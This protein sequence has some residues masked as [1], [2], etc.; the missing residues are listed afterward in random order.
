MLEAIYDTIRAI[1]W[2]E[3]PSDIS[4]API[5]WDQPIKKWLYGDRTLIE[6]TPSVL[7][8]GRTIDHK[9][10][11]N[12]INELTYQIS[13]SGWDRGSRIEVS[14]R[15]SLELTRL[16]YE[17]ILPHSIIWV[18]TPCPICLKKVL[19][20]SHFYY[21]HGPGAIGSSNVMSEEFNQAKEHFDSLWSESH[22]S[23]APN[24]ILSGLSTEAFNILYNNIITNGS[25]VGI[26]DT[27][28]FTAI[29]KNKMRPIRLLYEV[30]YTSINPVAI[31]RESEIFKGGEF[32]ISAKEL[33]RIPEFGP[34]NV[35]MN[36]YTWK[37]I[38]G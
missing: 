6:E 24:W 26:A 5:I 38:V 36:A 7:F 27:S 28:A 20:P 18:M 2:E 23:S 29:D 25:H 4:G 12:G 14:E 15:R 16:L 37:P 32:T 22:N 3:F 31:E 9:R 33:I 17:A 10:I 34:D 30:V 13:V 8:S 19:T 1:I 35:K 21:S 11:T